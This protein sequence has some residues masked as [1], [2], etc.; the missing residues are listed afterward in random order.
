MAELKDQVAA[1]GFAD[2]II[3]AGYQNEP[4]KYAAL[5]DVLALSSDTEQMPIAV[6]EA[7]AASKAIAATDVGDVGHMVCADNKPFINGHSADDLTQS[8]DSLLSLARDDKQAFV[9]LGAR[10]HERALQNHSDQVMA[11]S[12][13]DLYKSLMP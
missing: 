4:E 11:Q 3:L 5:M 8:L 12:W 10:N 9:L 13:Q 7:M 6:I 1:S 2:K